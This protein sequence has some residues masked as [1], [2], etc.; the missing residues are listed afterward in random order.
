[1]MPFSQSRCIVSLLSRLVQIAHTFNVDPMTAPNYRGNSFKMIL[2]ENTPTVPN[3]YWDSVL[4]HYA[5]ISFH[6]YFEGFPRMLPDMTTSSFL[7]KQDLLLGTPELAEELGYSDLCAVI[8]RR[9]LPDLQRFD[10]S[11]QMKLEKFEHGGLGPMELAL[12]WSEGLRLLVKKGFN[13]RKAFELACEISDEK[14]VSI[15]LSTDDPIF[16]CGYSGCPYWTFAKATLHSNE[17]IFRMVAEELRRRQELALYHLKREEPENIR[18]FKCWPSE[19]NG[20]LLYHSL[21]KRIAIPHK[22][23]CLMGGSPHCSEAMRCTDVL[24]YHRIL[25]KTGFTNLNVPCRH[26]MTPLAGYCDNYTGFSLVDE[27][28]ANWDDIVLWFLGKG[29]SFNFQLQSGSGPRWPH[30]LFYLVQEVETGKVSKKV[31]DACTYE[32]VTDQCRCFCSLRGCIPPLIFW[33]YPHRIY[34]YSQQRL[35]PT[36]FYDR[37][38]HL[39]RWAKVWRLSRIQKEDCYRDVCRRELFGR[40]GM[41]HTCCAARYH[42]PMEEMEQFWSEDQPSYQQLRFFLRLYRNT[43]KILFRYPIEEFWVVWWE[44]VDNILPRLPEEIDGW[45]Y[46]EHTYR[47]ALERREEQWAAKLESLGYGGLDF[48]EVIRHHSIKFLA[49]CK[50]LLERR[51]YRKFHRLVASSRSTVLKRRRHA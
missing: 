44:G 9:S 28:E 1:M 51:T 19:E 27:A 39:R 36:R 32:F 16:S 30:L 42:I 50:V 7:L 48:S 22:L 15:L 49:L 12:G 10:L 33:D 47:E 26:G 14:S 38:D 20:K 5:N 21:E 13:I 35:H 23:D 37:I 31:I 34:R 43:R 4:T 8:I 46:E 11:N 17:S 45:K 40:L 2:H 41:R 29:A 6:V 3:I 18:A 25:Y 24:P